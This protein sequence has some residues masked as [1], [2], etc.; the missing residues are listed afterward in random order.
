MRFEFPLCLSPND[1]EKFVLALQGKSQYCY[2]KNV[3]SW[4]CF[5][6][7]DP[8]SSNCETYVKVS[9]SLENGILDVEAEYSHNPRRKVECTLENV[10]YCQITLSNEEAI[11]LAKN[12]QTID[13]KNEKS[14]PKQSEE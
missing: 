12:L 11:S 7:F 6:S 13:L 10:F 1:I 9:L 3:Y 4:C 5:G 2:K 8:Q 14:E